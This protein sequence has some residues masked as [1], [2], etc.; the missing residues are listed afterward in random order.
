MAKKAIKSEKLTPFGGI[1]AMMEQFDS[2]LSYVIDSTLGM[3][4][5][6]YGYQ[7]SEIIR[8][9]M[10]VYFCGGSCIEDVTTHLMY[11]LSLHPTFRTCSADTILRAIKE[12]TQDNI[13]Y[14]SD[15]GKTYDFN[16][17]DMLNT[18]LLNCL[19]STGQLKEGEGYDVDFD[20]QFI[21]AEKF[22]AKPT[23]KKFLGYRP[24]VAVIG[25]MI[26]GIENSDGNTNVRFYQA[27]THKRFFALL[28]ANSIRVNRF[29]A[30]C[31]S[32]S[33]EIVS[34][35]EK[36]CTHFYIRAN[37]CSSLYDDL[38][39]LR[40][41]KTE[42][43]NGIQFE[44]N[45]IL[46]EKWEGKCYRLVIQRQ[47]RMDGE[48]DLWEGEYTYRCILT[49]DYEPSVREI[50]EFYNLRGGKER[51]FDEMNNGFG[52]NRL[53]KSFMGENTVFLL[54][55]ALIR[56][57]YKFIM[58][59]LDV[60]RFGLKATSRIKAFVFKFISV[61]AKWGR[62]S[63]QYVLNIYSCNNAYADVFQNDFG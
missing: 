3:R 21:E 43:I 6:L 46:V 52:W 9:L 8:S 15:T 53:P 44:L 62:T 40:G 19:L 56:N 20:H 25:D 11:H 14:T 37:R 2:T 49:N 7:Y 16:T 34:E 32:C 30:D 27:E 23:Y 35:I 38:F 24:G 60:K 10:S 1:F 51:I 55:T 42:E 13:S 45:S 26:V 18:L 12:L 59:R 63:R 39:S 57:F 33:K 28:E 47:K 61:P 4:C 50:V 54:L 17:A 58:A 5:R 22:D 41:W 29:R 36:H 31:G 48:L